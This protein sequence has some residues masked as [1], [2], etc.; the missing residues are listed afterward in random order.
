[1]AG[2]LRRIKDGGKCIDHHV[3]D[4]G[5]EGAPLPNPTK[6]VEERSHFT[7][8]I[9]SGATTRHQLH[10]P[11]NPAVIKTLP[12]QHFP[13]EGLLDRVIRFMEIDL[14]KDR[15][16]AFYFDLMEHFMNN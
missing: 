14:K 7:I 9:S 13:K 11:G 15:L 2:S 1:M 6:G 12:E 4:E 3:E 5:E 16:L 10:D 8:N